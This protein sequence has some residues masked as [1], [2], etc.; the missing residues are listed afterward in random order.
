MTGCMMHY[1]DNMVFMDRSKYFEKLASYFSLI[2]GYELFSERRM[3]HISEL[4]KEVG[5]GNTDT[6]ERDIADLIMEIMKENIFELIFAPDDCVVSEEKIVKIT[7]AYVLIINE[8]RRPL[9]I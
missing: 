4:L 1:G 8:I 2:V 6:N 7:N 5:S 9:E 3:M